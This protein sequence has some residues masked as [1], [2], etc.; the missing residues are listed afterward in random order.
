VGGGKAVSFNGAP[1]AQRVV[2]L[3]FKSMDKA[4]EWWSSPARRDASTIGDKYATFRN[5]A[6]EGVA[7]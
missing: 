4:Q 1:P 3:Q 2:V 7:Q 5:F 6:V